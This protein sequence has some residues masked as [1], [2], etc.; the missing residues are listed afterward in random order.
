[1]IPKIFIPI[2]TLV[3][4]QFLNETDVYSQYANPRCNDFSILTKQ[5]IK[6]GPLVS[7]IVDEFLVNDKTFSIADLTFASKELQAF[8]QL[9]VENDYECFNI[10]TSRG[11][12][13]SIIQVW[14]T[15]QDSKVS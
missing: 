12:Y 11:R 1:M 3:T 2:L 13:A 9:E 8:C 5:N 14:D 4:A 7:K 15:N 10:S 6:V